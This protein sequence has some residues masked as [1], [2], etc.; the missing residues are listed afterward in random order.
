MTDSKPPKIGG[1][2][3]DA[4]YTLQTPTQRGEIPEE[5]RTENKEEEKHR[6]GKKH[7]TKST[8]TTDSANTT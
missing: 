7:E 2:K 4:G 3:N 5:T 8:T 6:H 1:Y